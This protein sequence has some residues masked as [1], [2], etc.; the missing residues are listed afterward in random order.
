KI[1][2]RQLRRVFKGRHLDG[3]VAAANRVA[4][5]RHFTGKAAVHRIV[6]QQMRIGLDRREI[7][8]GDDFGIVALGFDDRTQDIAAD[9]A[10]SINGNANGHSRS[11]YSY[12][13]RRSGVSL[14]CDGDNRHPFRPASS[15]LTWSKIR[16]TDV[17]PAPDDP[18]TEIMGCLTD[19]APHSRSN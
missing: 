11:P 19:T 14:R 17:V 12:N 7:V 18:V 13:A 9:T 2:P 8:D 3:A 16:R 4:L 10:E 1:F 6:A 5:D 15:L